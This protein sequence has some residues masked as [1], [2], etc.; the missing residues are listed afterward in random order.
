MQDSMFGAGTVGCVRLMSLG[1]S[2]EHLSSLS[3][4]ETTL[5]GAGTVGCVRLMSLG[6]SA[7]HLSSLSNV[8]TTLFSTCW[9]NV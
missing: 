9:N 7:E 8:E 4:V 6:N 5:F 2:A 1:N 3:N